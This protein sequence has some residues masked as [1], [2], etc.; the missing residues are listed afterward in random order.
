MVVFCPFYSGIS[1]GVRK[2]RMESQGAWQAAL[3][4]RRKGGD[5]REAVNGL[6]REF[7]R[8][9]LEEMN[10]CFKDSSWRREKWYVEDTDRKQQI[11]FW[12]IG[13]RQE[14]GSGKGTECWPAVRRDMCIMRC[15]PE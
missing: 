10:R 11:M 2:G 4:E 8:L 3:V 12:R 15:P 1:E 7:I 6:G 13:V 5:G 9:T 14:N